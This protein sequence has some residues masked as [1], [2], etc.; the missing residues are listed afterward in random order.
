[1]DEPKVTVLGAPTKNPEDMKD[2][3][4]T[5]RKRAA[6]LKPIIEDMICDWAGLLNAGG[7]I[8]PIVGCTGVKLT[9][10]KGNEVRTGNIHHGPDKDVLNNSD[11][12]LHRVCSR[13]HNRWHA[14]NDPAYPKSRPTPGTPFVPVD[15]EI[16]AH[17]KYTKA[18]EEQL[19]FSEAWWA[20]KPASKRTGTFRKE[21]NV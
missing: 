21:D 13:C 9:K 19:A 14:L 7:G 6:Q 4:S 8:T 3:V 17:D 20:I 11:E 12:N 18:T 15:A 1:L 5:G 10:E 2:P 16:V